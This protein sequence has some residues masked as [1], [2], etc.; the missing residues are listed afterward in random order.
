MLD[1]TSDIPGDGLS[2]EAT[3]KTPANDQALLDAY[4]NAVIGVTKPDQKSATRAS[5]AGL[6]PAS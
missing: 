3:E 2:P 6:V 1:L 4:S 5:G